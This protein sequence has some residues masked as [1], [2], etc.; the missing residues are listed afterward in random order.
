MQNTTITGR[1]IAA[2]LNLKE[3]TFR[4]KRHEL[5]ERGMPRPVWGLVWSRALIEAWINQT[6]AQP[7]QQINDYV[8]QASQALANKY[9]RVAS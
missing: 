8:G 1:E 4:R 6:P 3:V 9:T 5:I 7:Q 2:L